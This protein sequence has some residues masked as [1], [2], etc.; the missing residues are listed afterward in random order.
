M[1][2]VV[3]DISFAIVKKY[4]FPFLVILLFLLVL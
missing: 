4:F 3:L 2:A 1:R